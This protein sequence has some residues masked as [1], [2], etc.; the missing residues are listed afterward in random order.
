[1]CPPQVAQKD[2]LDKKDVEQWILS[3]RPVPGQIQPVRIGRWVVGKVKKSA[4]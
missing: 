4:R 1:M 2:D 3:D